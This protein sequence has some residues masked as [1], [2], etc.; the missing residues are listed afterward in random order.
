M[1]FDPIISFVSC[2]V[3]PMSTLQ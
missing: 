2:Q 3:L 1:S